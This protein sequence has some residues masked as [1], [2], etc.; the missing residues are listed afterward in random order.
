[1]SISARTEERR[2]ARCFAVSSWLRREERVER[3]SRRISRWRERLEV[4]RV[5]GEGSESR[6]RVREE[7]RVSRCGKREKIS[8]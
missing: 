4:F 7:R 3:W 2:F 8:A 5:E 1:M 6:R